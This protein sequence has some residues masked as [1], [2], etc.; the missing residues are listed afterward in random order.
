MF[1]LLVPSAVL[2]AALAGGGLASE[3]A[4][5]AWVDPVTG[6]LR[7]PVRGEEAALAPGRGDGHDGLVEVPGTSPAGGFAIH[8]GGRFQAAL[9]AQVGPRGDV[10]TRCERAD[11]ASSDAPVAG[12]SETFVRASPPSPSATTF[13]ILNQDGPGEGLNDS[14]PRSPVGG[15]TGTTLGEQRLNALKYAAGLWASR[16]R[17]DVPIRMQAKFDAL[18]CQATAAVLGSAGGI[19][20]HRDFVG[21][22]RPGTWYPSAL[23]SMMAERDLD[24]A[25]DD[26]QSRFNS[27]LDAGCPFPRRWYYGFDQRAGA[28]EIDFVTI[29]NHE[30]AHGL[31]FQTYVDLSTGARLQGRDDIFLVHLYDASKGKRWQLLTDGERAASAVND[32]GLLW[33]GALANSR[34]GIFTSGVG[35]GG[36]LRMYAPR[37]LVSGSSVVHWDTALVPDESLEPFYTA[38]MHQFLTTVELMR[39][40]GWSSTATTPYSWILPSSA[41]V[42]GQGGAYYVT[43]LLIANRGSTDAAIVLK[44]LGHD[45]DGTVGPEV[46]V[47]LSAGKS[48][49]YEDVLSGVFS[50]SE[51]YGAIRISSSTPSLAVLSQTSTAADACVGGTFGQSVPAF[52]PADLVVEGTPRVILGVRED[53]AFRTNL[54]LANSSESEVEVEVAL[55]NDAGTILGTPRSYRLPPLGMTQVSGVVRQLGVT[56]DVPR[57]RLLVSTS[58]PDGEFAAYAAVIDNRTTDPRTLLPR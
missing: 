3:P 49:T 53:G 14:S 47:A 22:A 45:R 16:V 44:F 18:S 7:A 4:Q 51:D 26:I 37:T 52:G 41:R 57:A 12:A 54:V 13:V 38:P 21:V 2:A 19:Q 20:L 35:A 10:T 15:N 9:V 28:N 43:D 24:A 48:V 34:S 6:E 23:A 56:G 58:T 39:D 27:S 32:G 55:Q 50:L 25:V 36:R 17:T 29:V 5:R 42:P 31:G 33:D 30:I 40:L 1:R 11:P 46:P 8:L